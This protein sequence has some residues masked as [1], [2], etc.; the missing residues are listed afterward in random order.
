MVRLALAVLL[1]LPSAPSSHA[2]HRQTPPVVEFTSEDAGAKGDA[3]LF[4][5]SAG[6]GA[7]AA[8]ITT[9]APTGPPQTKIIRYRLL[10]AFQNT[11]IA[12][13]ADTSTKLVTGLHYSDP[14]IS[15]FGGAVVYVTENATG[16]PQVDLHSGGFRNDITPVSNDSTGTSG[17]PA[18]SGNGRRIAFESNGDLASTGNTTRQVFV[19]DSDATDTPTQISV[20]E[21][22]AGNA[23]LD[24]LGHRIAFESTSDPATLVDTGIPQVWEADLLTN[25]AA[26]ITKGKGASGKPMFSSE[27]T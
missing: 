14:A 17:N 23:S 16:K 2:H 11:V 20:G 10:G 22:T 21:G 9:P 1:V 27:G 19:V 4:R 7:F 5:A 13:S 8:L 15:F 24:R 18:V 12:D 3:Q 25:Q 26:P 6:P